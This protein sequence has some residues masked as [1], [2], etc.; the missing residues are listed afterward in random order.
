MHNQSM[1]NQFVTKLVFLIKENVTQR[2]LPVTFLMDVLSIG[3]EAAYRRLRGEITFSFDDMIRIS[4]KLGVSLDEIADMEDWADKSNWV[5]FN[6]ES[7]NFPPSNSFTALY[8]ENLK[9]FIDI[10]SEMEEPGSIFRGATLSIPY[11]FLLHYKKLSL[12]RHYKWTYLTQSIDRDFSFSKMTVPAVSLELEK[13]FIESFEKIA[14]ILCIINQDIFY[15]MVKDIKYFFYENLISQKEVME[16]KVE[17][18]DLLSF[19]ESL[20]ATGAYENGGEIDI[21]LSDVNIDSSYVHIEND[22]KEYAVNL[23][24]FIDVIV[25][26]NQKMCQKQKKWIE[27]LKRFSTLITQTGEK[28]RFEFF[29]NQREM[30][31]ELLP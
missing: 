21:F 24:Y 13:Q 17:L 10:F 26:K 4:K 9:K 22:T 29:R 5:K 11:F 12:F 3:K 2:M 30:I 23:G 20:T 14:R 27:L 6:L 7:L 28:K 15:N 18:L 31:E 19:I 25:Y 8:F 16:L 1:T